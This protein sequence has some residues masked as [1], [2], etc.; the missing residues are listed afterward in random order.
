MVDCISSQLYCS[1]DKSRRDRKKKKKAK[2]NLTNYFIT[3][4][5]NII[6]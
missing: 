5:Y 2:N 1:N 3:I 6:I 4:K